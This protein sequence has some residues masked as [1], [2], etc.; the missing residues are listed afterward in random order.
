MKRLRKNKKEFAAIIEKQGRDCR[1]K[2]EKK[3]GIYIINRMY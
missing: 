3:K 2:D 1:L